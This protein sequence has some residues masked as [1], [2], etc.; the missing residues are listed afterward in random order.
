MAGDIGGMPFANVFH[1]GTDEPGISTGAGVLDMITAFK[2]AVS[3]S[4]L[5]TLL[6]NTLHVTQFQGVVQLT[7]DT[8]VEATLSASLAG[9]GS[10]ATVTANDALVISWLSNAYWRGGKP[11]TY[12]P[13]LLTASVD[14][15]HSL[16][17]SSKAAF[18]ANAVAFRTAVNAITTPAVDATQLGFVSYATGKAWRSTP[19]FFPYTGVTIHDRIGS[20]RR[21][22]GRW[23]P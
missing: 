9:T 12:L 17:D 4:N 19:L 16:L 10:G 18:L 21:R 15:N 22:L 11:R 7:D 13:G 8:A 2:N 6:S 23:L 1:V 5:I 3:S 14:T 20:Q